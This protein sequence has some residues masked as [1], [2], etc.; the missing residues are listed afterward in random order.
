MSFE[1]I[2]HKYNTSSIGAGIT[3]APF[4]MRE[5]IERLPVELMYKGM[6]LVD[7]NKVLEIIDAERPEGREVLPQS[8]VEKMQQQLQEIRR[9]S[10]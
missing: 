4:V 5:K 7:L 1:G 10:L 6:R 9:W 8:T 3:P 2:P